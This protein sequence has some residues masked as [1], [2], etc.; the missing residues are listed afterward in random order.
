M[1][2]LNSY[3]ENYEATRRKNELSEQSGIRHLTEEEI[4]ELDELHDSIADFEEIL[5]NFD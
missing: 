4:Q 2:K 1:V 5:L 3:L